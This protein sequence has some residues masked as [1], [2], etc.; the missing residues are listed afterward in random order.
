MPVLE[1]LLSAT[2]QRAVQTFDKLLVRLTYEFGGMLG[3]NEKSVLPV[4]AF[5]VSSVPED[6]IL[7]LCNMLWESNECR[8]V[9]SKGDLDGFA[10]VLQIAMGVCAHRNRALLP[11]L[12]D[13]FFT[14]MQRKNIAIKGSWEG[15]RS[16]AVARWMAQEKFIDWETNTEL[17]EA[18]S[19]RT[20]PAHTLNVFAESCNTN[21]TSVLRMLGNIV[22]IPDHLA[23]YRLS[24]RAEQICRAIRY[25]HAPTNY[26]LEAD[27]VL[28]A[29]PQATDGIL[30]HCLH[31]TDPVKVNV[32]EMGSVF[33]ALQQGPFDSTQVNSS[34]VKMFN[35]FF[36]M[37][38]LPPT[39]RHLPVLEKMCQN[40]LDCDFPIL[41]AWVQRCKLLQTT[42][43]FSLHKTRVM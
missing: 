27:D 28:F 23:A 42:P 29:T 20:I 18:L 33:K 1:K 8:K 26:N 14:S 32:G 43:T 5:V 25:N 2:D 13:G 24:T 37:L 4:V 17:F 3:V 35:M 15:V 34:A 19:V 12:L 40:S 10:T 6:K 41:H 31:P 38:E 30:Q 39:T 36:A 7:S 16:A 11:P 22:P 21:N 9:D